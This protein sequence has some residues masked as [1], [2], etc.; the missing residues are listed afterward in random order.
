[1]DIVL[2]LVRSLLR[3]EDIRLDP[4]LG[5]AELEDKVADSDASVDAADAALCD[6]LFDEECRRKN[7]SC[8][9]RRMTRMEIASALGLNPQCEET[10]KALQTMLDIGVDRGEF[11]LEDDGCYRLRA[12]HLA[13]EREGGDGENDAD[14]HALTTADAAKLVNKLL[15]NDPPLTENGCKAWLH[16]R[17]IQG[18]TRDEW[19]KR[20]K[21]EPQRTAGN[22]RF[23]D[24]AAI[25][26]VFGKDFVAQH[27]TEALV[28]EMVDKREA[29]RQ[30]VKDS[31]KP[32]PIP[33]KTDLDEDGFLP[34]PRSEK[35]R[36]MGRSL[37]QRDNSQG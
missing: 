8:C 35:L 22:P 11:A 4:K 12:C 1:M 10:K 31:K 30:E 25:T 27:K 16:D 17:G 20:F 13:K 7:G 5:Y 21:T 18:Y 14:P 24:Y 6:A 15:A 19:R 37:R 3:G 33:Q 34:D 23:Y 32:H 36:K 2:G 9:P 29:T 28:Q 26:A